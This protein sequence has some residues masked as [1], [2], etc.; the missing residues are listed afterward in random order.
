[1][2][3]PTAARRSSSPAG[4]KKS[5]DA[6]LRNSL[7]PP[8]IVLQSDHGY[9]RGEAWKGL[10]APALEER[11]SI[12]NAYLVPDPCR[13][14]LYP[15]ITPVNSFRVLF[16][17]AFSATLPLLPDLTYYSP[18]PA[19]SGYQFHLVEAPGSLP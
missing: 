11:T 10:G 5:I 9:G 14:S 2:W 12:L 18:N 16:D 8:I 6:I 19:D 1:M 17:C 7:S 13:D 4:L 15:S 3:P